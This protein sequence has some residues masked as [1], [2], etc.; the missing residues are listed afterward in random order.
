M[1][2]ILVATDGSD[3]AKKALLEAKKLAECLDAKV[4]I[5]NAVNNIVINP[6]LTEQD[7]TLKTNENLMKLGEDLLQE[8]LKLFDD[9]K[10]EVK[11]KLRA[12]NPGNIIIKE[13]EKE[14]Y[15]LVVIGS[16]GLG[17]FSRAMMGSVSN[18]V[19]NHV[20]ANVLVVK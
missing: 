4:V 17:G 20:D 1:K 3:N 18:K 5:L 7:Y 10:G 15:D 16:R 9:F 19:L 2:K 12:G 11:T 14:N 8:A 6:Y 13:V